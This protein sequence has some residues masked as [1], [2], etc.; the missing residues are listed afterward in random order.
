MTPAAV[1]RATAVRAAVAVAIAMLLAAGC[2]GNGSSATATTAQATTTMTSTTPTTPTTTP[3]AASSTVTTT[4]AT[5][6]S[7]G[8]DDLIGADLVAL[9]APEDVQAAAS[10]FAEVRRAGR[11]PDRRLGGDL[12]FIL[13]D[14]RPLLMVVVQSADSFDEWKAD[15]DSYREDLGG[16]GEAAFIGPA[17]AMNEAPYLLVFRSGGRTVGLFTYDDPDV[18]GWNNLLTL[19]QL[20]ALARVIVGHL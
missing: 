9:L 4:I 2:T 15:L 20:Q 17:V 3:T 1:R 7:S 5:S 6:D 10:G 16:V 18:E 12:N 13:P 11:N 8:G 19:E 14:G